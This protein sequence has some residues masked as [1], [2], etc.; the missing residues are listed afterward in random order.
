MTSSR[1]EPTPKGSLSRSVVISL[2]DILTTFSLILSFGL[3]L[4]FP[5]SFWP[6]ISTGLGRLHSR[7]KSPDLSKTIET[8][9][10]AG[11]EITES[12]LVR[13]LLAGTYLEN[14]EAMSEYL[15][16]R[17]S[18]HIKVNGLQHVKQA[19]ER[20][21][22]VIFWCPPVCGAQAVLL[23]AY[24]DL[25]MPVTRL[26]SIVHPLSSTRFGRRVLN[27]LRTGVETRHL[28]SIVLLEPGK[29]QMAIMKMMRLLHNNEIVMVAAI[30]SGQDPLEAP[31]L[32]GTLRL[33]KGVPAMAAATQSAIIPT[34][35][36]L[37]G[38]SGYVLEFDPPLSAACADSD[39]DPLQNYADLFAE[40]LERKLC[41]DPVHWRGWIM[42]HTWSP[43]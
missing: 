19:L 31:L 15:G 18:P 23:R 12:Q 20:G 3:A 21:R 14:I 42:G 26:Q 11:M 2:E 17:G 25:G 5:R 43:N 4:L 13:H 16:F 29:D 24:S 35:F 6:G 40:R 41:N 37:R 34:W 28:A 22:G 32:G 7:L 10:Q 33:A 36:S 27:P 8:V 9:N 1:S 30:G 38:K 39:R